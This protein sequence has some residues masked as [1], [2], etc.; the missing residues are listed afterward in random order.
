MFRRLLVA[1]DGSACS[2]D[3]L[4]VALDL[5]AAHSGELAICSVA[6]PLGDEV[7]R[8]AVEDARRLADA[9]GISCTAKVIEGTSPAVALLAY[10]KQIDADCIVAGTHGRSGFAKALY[11]SVARELLESAE[12]AVLTVRRARQAPR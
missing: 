1:L 3:G 10:A 4:G 7:A 5:A 12:C 2:H 6:E 9:R 8:E 11:G